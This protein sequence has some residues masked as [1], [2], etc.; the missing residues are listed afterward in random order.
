MKLLLLSLALSLPAFAGM[1]AKL[2]KGDLHLSAAN[3][4]IVSTEEICPA[5]T[6]PGQGSC[7]AYGTNVKIKITMTGCLDRLGGFFYD[8]KE[9]YGVGVI[10]LGAINI[11]NKASM[12][13]RCVRMPSKTVTLAIPYK[14]EIQL[15]SMDLNVP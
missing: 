1:S 3:M 14:G 7:M 10:K 12:T 4:E 5:P 9:E 2:Q 8:F 11:F 6:E 15:Q 13:A